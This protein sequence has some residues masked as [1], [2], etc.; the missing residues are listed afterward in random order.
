VQLAGVTVHMAPAGTEALTGHAA[1]M[2][3][4]DL[5]LDRMQAD[6]TTK[7]DGVLS[8]AQPVVSVDHKKWPKHTPTTS[9]AH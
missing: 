1:D 8:A 5:Q 7:R 3:S 4:R 2:F 9:A 6:V